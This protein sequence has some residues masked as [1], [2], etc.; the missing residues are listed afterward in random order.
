MNSNKLNQN[1]N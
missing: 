1:L